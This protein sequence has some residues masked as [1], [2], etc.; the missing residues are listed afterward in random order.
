MS[1]GEELVEKLLGMTNTF[2]NGI[3]Y[4]L[5]MGQIHFAIGTNTFCNGIK[6]IKQIGLNTFSKW[7]KYI[8][9]L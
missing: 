3:K 6:Y 8:L 5:Q 1:G 2:C 4:I 7:D 9:Q